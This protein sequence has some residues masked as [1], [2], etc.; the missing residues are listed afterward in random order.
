MTTRFMGTPLERRSVLRGAGLGL[1]GLAGAA[2]LGC[3]GK[4]DSGASSGSTSSG[5]ASGAPKNIKRAEGFDAKFGQLPIN[6]KKVVK[7][8]T[9]RRQRNDTSRENDPEVSIAGADWEIVGDRLFYANGFTMAVTPDML[10]SYEWIDKQNLVLK[11]R[12]GI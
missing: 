12:P 10:A 3:G 6:D 1:A 2:L 7:G 4:S 8:G 11:L 9:F 5:G